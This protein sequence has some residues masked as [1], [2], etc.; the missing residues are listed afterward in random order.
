MAGTKHGGGHDDPDREGGTGVVEETE[1][2][3]KKPQLYKVLLHNDDYTTMDFV[4]MVLMNIFHHQQAEAAR[5][6]LAVHKAGIGVAGVYSYEVA[7]TKA[8]KVIEL[9]KNNEYPLQC[10]VEPA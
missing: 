1:Q 7:E 8:R 2:K 5:I 10:S 3:L 9:A 4:V 6:M